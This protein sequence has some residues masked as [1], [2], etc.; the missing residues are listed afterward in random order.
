M[1]QF[2]Q[3]RIRGSSHRA[4]PKALLSPY[5]YLIDP[6]LNGERRAESRRSATITQ[7]ELRQRGDNLIISHAHDFHMHRE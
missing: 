6:Q 7:C 1:M 2:L 5:R 4:S 3:R